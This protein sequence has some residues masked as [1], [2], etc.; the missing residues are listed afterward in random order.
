MSIKAD[1][2]LGTITY[3]GDRVNNSSITELAN[4]WYRL[5]MSSTSGANQTSYRYEISLLDDNENESYLG[6]GRGLYLAYAQLEEQASATSLML[7]ITEGSTTSRVADACNGSGTAQDFKDYNTSG[8]LYAEIAANSDD[9]TGRWITICDGTYSNFASIYYHSTSNQVVGRLSVSGGQAEITY[10]LT[11]STEFSKIAF[12]YAVNDF[13]LWVDGVER[14][15]DT[16]G[17]TFS[18]NTL[19]EVTLSDAGGA[20]NFYG[21]TRAVEVLPYMSDEEMV[22]LTT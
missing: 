5:S 16:S 19:N 9:G 17:I 1:L 13:S 6:S 18:A 14:G 2:S 3:E 12:R 10:T 4:G 11:D 15:T 22:T 8:V 7:P 20:D 21:K